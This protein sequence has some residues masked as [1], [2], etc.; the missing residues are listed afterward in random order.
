VLP[1]VVV[2]LAPLRANRTPT[3]PLLALSK[4][5]GVALELVHVR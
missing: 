4:V 2:E 1:Q 5:T 3:W